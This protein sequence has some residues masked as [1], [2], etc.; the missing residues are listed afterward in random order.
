MESKNHEVTHEKKVDCKASVIRIPVTKDY[1]QKIFMPST[2]KW[3]EFNQTDDVLEIS[4]KE[5]L[6]Q[7]RQVNIICLCEGK[8]NINC[9]IIQKGQK[10]SGL[11][12]EI[13]ETIKDTFIH[14][15]NAGKY[16]APW[17]TS[18]IVRVGW[19]IDAVGFKYGNKSI[20]IG[21]TGGNLKEIPLQAGEYITAI[22]GSYTNYEGYL[23]YNSITF[24][25]NRNNYS[26]KGEKNY[27]DIGKISYSA[28]AGNAI[29]CLYGVSNNKYLGALGFY[30]TAID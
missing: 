24:H 3:F 15:Y 6:S 4:I 21:G 5:N 10:K 13:K 8:S 18:I 30:E 27:K 16:P 12:P 23:V 26:L 14:E 28:E 22:S 9:I 2:P 11:Y 17:P 1:T 25:T 19:I 20:Q 29:F 7:E